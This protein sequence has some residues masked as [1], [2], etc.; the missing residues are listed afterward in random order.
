MLICDRCRQKLRF[1]D[2]ATAW[3]RAKKVIGFTART[4]RHQVTG[5]NSVTGERYLREAYNEMV[6]AQKANYDRQAMEAS[7]WRNQP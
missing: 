6:D 1:Q 2:W 4:I 5:L 3:C 7:Y